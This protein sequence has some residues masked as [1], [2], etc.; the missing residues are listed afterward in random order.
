MKKLQENEKILKENAE[1]CYKFVTN[2]IEFFEKQQNL[3]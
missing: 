2:I 3:K 1:K